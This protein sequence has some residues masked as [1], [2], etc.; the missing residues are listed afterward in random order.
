MP[1]KLIF[2]G[3][4]DDASEWRI[5]GIRFSSIGH[6]NEI[7]SSLVEVLELLGRYACA[8]PE[9]PTLLADAFSRDIAAA[10]A[11]SSVPLP[12]RPPFFL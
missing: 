2:Y 11:C 9:F 7:D 3:S 5:V 6:L 8:T 4:D 1:L 10:L 12:T